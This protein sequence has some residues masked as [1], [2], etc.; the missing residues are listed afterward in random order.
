MKK[1]Y[2][3]IIA[4]TQWWTETVEADYFT[5]NVGYYSFHIDIG[6]GVVACY[7]MNR[8]IITKIELIEDEF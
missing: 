1:Y 7:P 5:A 3:T 4:G 8:T 2:L 6:N